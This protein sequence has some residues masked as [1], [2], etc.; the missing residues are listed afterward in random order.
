[1]FKGD[2]SG[3]T[4]TGEYKVQG[5]TII[6]TSDLRV[7]DLI[8]VK[9][10]AITVL[11]SI[12][13]SILTVSQQNPFETT[14][15]INGSQHITISH[16]EEQMVKVPLA[17]IETLSVRSFMVDWHINNLE[18]QI[19]EGTTLIEIVLDDTKGIWNAF[20]ENNKFL[21]QRGRLLN[22]LDDDFV[23]LREPNGRCN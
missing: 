21:I 20:F 19:S 12:Y 22:V 14:L 7:S 23:F 18:F 6:L 10:R 3:Q 13:I 2:V 4:S 15:L 9:Q 16:T 8:Q 5:D 1:M 17:S 11:D